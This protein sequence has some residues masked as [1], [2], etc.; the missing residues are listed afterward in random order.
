MFHG[1][2]FY[3]VTIHSNEA[4]MKFNKWFRQYIL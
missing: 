3:V 4:F 2:Y 1:N